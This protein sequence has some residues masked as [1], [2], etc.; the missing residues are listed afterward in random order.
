MEIGLVLEKLIRI[1]D[2]HRVFI[3]AR[4]LSP[5]IGQRGSSSEFGNC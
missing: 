2:M 4:I 5:L 1:L 3:Q